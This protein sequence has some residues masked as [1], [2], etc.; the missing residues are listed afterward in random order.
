MISFFEESSKTTALRKPFIEDYVEQNPNDSS[1]YTVYS[2]S[3]TKKRTGYLLNTRKFTIMLF[4]GSQILNQLMEALA[5]WHAQGHGYK[6]VVQ[7]HPN[8]PFYQLGTD[9]DSPCNWMSE[10][11]KYFIA[12]EATTTTSEQSVTRNPFLPLPS[13]RKHKKQSTPTTPTENPS[14]DA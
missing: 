2:V 9:F 8:Y 10:R 12:Q 6:L 14:S 7:L 11:G 3:R 13:T 4:E 5:S 1:I